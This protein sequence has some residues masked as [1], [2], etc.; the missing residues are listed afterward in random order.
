MGT[1]GTLAELKKEGFKTFHPFIN[2]DYDLIEN[3]NDRCIAVLNEL[4]RIVYLSNEEKIEWMK[5]VKPIVDYN[6]RHLINFKI[7]YKKRVQQR[8]QELFK[9]FDYNEK[10]I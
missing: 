6:F 7:K 4:K 5:N 1:L 9:K 10:I 3:M 2:E 8:T